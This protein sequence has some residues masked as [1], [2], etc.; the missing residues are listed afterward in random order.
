MKGMEDD[1]RRRCFGSV[2]SGLIRSDL[3]LMLTDRTSAPPQPR[4]YFHLSCNIE[5]SYNLLLSKSRVACSGTLN[6]GL[7][8]NSLA[9]MHVF[10]ACSE[11]G[12]PTPVNI[13]LSLSLPSSERR[14]P[15]QEATL[16]H[17][18]FPRSTD[19]NC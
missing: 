17:S 7:C 8:S 12:M 19:D 14:I 5:K 1:G 2:K 6:L 13:A 16:S 18:C 9:C 10:T 3:L 15:K 4:V 11:C